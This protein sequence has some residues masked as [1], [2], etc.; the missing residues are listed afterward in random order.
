MPAE[1]E[2]VLPP[3]I[4]SRQ[5]ETAQGLS[6]HY[7][8]AGRTDDPVLLLLHGFPELAFSWRKVMPALAASG[9]RVIAPDQRGYGR[10][11]GWAAGYEVDLEPYRMPSLVLDQLALLSALDI[12]QVYGV[13]GH[14]FGS[15]VAAWCA[16]IRPDLFG[17]VVMM[18]APF[19]G[20]PGFGGGARHAI[21]DLLG[22]LPVP[23]KH[24]QWYYATEPA[25]A[26]MLSCEQ[27]L[28][29]FLA[30][31]YYLKSGLWA[32]NDPQPLA[33]WNAQSLARMPNYYVLPLASTM[34][35]A[36]AQD[37]QGEDLGRLHEWLTDSALDVY[38]AEF[39]RT[40]FQGGL[41]WYRASTSP[42]ENRPLRLFA[43]TRIQVPAAFIA[44][45]RDWGI[46]QTPGVLAAMAERA[47]TDF[48]GQHLISG[49]G[50]WVQQEAPEELADL[51]IR[52]MR[53]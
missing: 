9:Y 52:F 3:G 29:T 50:H 53:S 30:G 28:K 12:A 17:R 46:Y 10:T 36:V 45:D 25:E 44:G 13:V 23:R 39:S 51:L 19:G 33:G 20:P 8:E 4:E 34:A 31:Y 1:L 49:A 22:E 47:C 40:G 48:R 11:T 5:V 14:D 42:E 24:Y 27:G 15:P 38:C 21:D 32:A 6:V 41:N 16:L 35:E 18:S 7:L 37:C 26:D 2:D 43:G